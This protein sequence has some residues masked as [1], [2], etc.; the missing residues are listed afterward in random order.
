ASREIVGR[1]LCE[2]VDRVRRLRRYRERIRPEIENEEI[3]SGGERGNLCRAAI[4]HRGE[5][6]PIASNER[7]RCRRDNRGEIWLNIWGAVALTGAI[8]QRKQEI[9]PIIRRG[10]A[11]RRDRQLRRRHLLGIDQQAHGLSG[12]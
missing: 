5:D 12:A 10:S 1:T 2:R 8:E 9:V 3:S 7:E 11:F 6:V 4:R